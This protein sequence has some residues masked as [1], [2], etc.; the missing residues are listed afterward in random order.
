MSRFFWYWRRHLTARL[1][2]TFFLLTLITTG[3]VGLM[4]YM[5]ARRSMTM[6]VYERLHA[7]AAF[8]EDS[9]RRWNDQQRLNLVFI[10]RLPEVRMQSG[11]LLDQSSSA[12]G[13][14]SDAYHALAEYLQFVISSVPDYEEL[15]IMNTKGTVI[16]STQ[17]A[18]EGT[19]RKNAEYFLMGMSNTYVQPFYN[20]AETGQP[21]ITVV[22]PLFNEDKRRVGVLAGHLNLARVDRFILERTGLGETG[23][24]YLVNKYHQFVSASNYNRLG[25]SRREEIRSIGIDNALKGGQVE[26]LHANYMGIPVI[27][28]Y[29]WLDDQNVVLVTEINQE[30]A[31]E[32]ASQLA[33]TVAELGLLIGLFLGGVV[34]FLSRQVTQPI[35][36]ISQTAA[37]V[38]SGD[39][40]QTAPV[41][42]RDEVGTLA[43][44]FNNMTGE[45]R[46]LYEG[47]EKKV[48]ERTHDLQQA[49]LRLQEEISERERAEDQLRRQN[50]Y[51]AA[52]QETTLGVISHLDLTDLFETLVTRAGSMM[53]T[54]HGVIYIIEPESNESVCRI[55]IGAFTNLVGL[56]LKPGEGLGGKIMQTGEPVIIENYDQWSDRAKVIEPGLI[57]S[58][59]GVPLISGTQIVGAISLAY[60]CQ[61]DASHDF[62][63]HEID[64][65]KQF[66][67]LAVLAL[68]NARLYTTA[69]EAR[70][71]AELANQIKSDFLASVSH[72]LRTPLTSIIGFTSLVQKRLQERIIPLLSMD[73]SR[74]QRTTAQIEANLHIIFSEGDRLT[75]LINDLLDLE[76]IQSG[77]MNWHMEAVQIL[78]VIA[79]AE[80]ATS[81]LFTNKGLTWSLN[82]PEFL[83]SIVGDPDR[84]L[85]VIINL[86]SNAI[87]FTEAGSVTCKAAQ[88]GCN[89]VISI[90][91][92]GIGISKE[93]QPLVFEKFK[94][95][96]D[97]LT[98]KPKG[99]GLGLSICK[100]IIE[101][102]GGT[103]WVESILGQG[104]TFSF[105]LPVPDCEG[106]NI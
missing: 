100:E 91:D 31:F 49:N 41:M 43:Q 27:G 7:I 56:R 52:L 67:H 83:P 55:G 44:S 103:I 14:T 19:S 106:I 23:E 37:R 9:L 89:L 98:G 40:T 5:Q 87:K 12:A 50:H 35:L 8:K 59:V 102:H 16:L 1:A 96:G 94:Q 11:L 62:G 2:G 61:A 42:T 77:K 79:R 82:V 53:D 22:T 10:A 17:K 104:S 21:A 65:L 48:I 95:V 75:K 69:V 76:K 70:A 85:Q 15:F 66:A 28:Y 63:E 93:D 34:Y 60:D 47:L 46:L 88:V 81:S 84:L 72:E 29:S 86:I 33:K 73:D 30:E 18:N 51:L 71:A 101:N 36:A 80:A 90:M 92:Q 13:N 3:V 68:D 6:T 97:T 39:L 54:E 24:A 105:T 99:T 32:P 57:R 25:T 78:V 4:V 58:A 38:A 20:S 74:I 64:L 45:L 26:G